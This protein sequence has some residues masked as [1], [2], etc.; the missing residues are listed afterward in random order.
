MQLADFGSTLSKDS[1]YAKQ[2]TQVGTPV[3]VGPEVF[4]ELQ[5]STSLDIWSFGATVSSRSMKQ[6]KYMT[7]RLVFKLISLMYGDGFDVFDPHIPE[8]HN[9]Y[10]AQILFK[11][12]RVFGPFPYE[13]I[14]DD[15][16]IGAITMIMQNSP[17]ETLRSFHRVVAK[18]I[19]EDDKAF[20][21]RIMKLDPRDR[22][23]AKQLLEDVWFR[24]GDA[25]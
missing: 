22:L 4:L 1:T 9:E 17:L 6:R 23:T 25:S 15:L 14:A 16:K 20:V 18:E 11:H 21:L 5:W 24:R 19:S 13:E 3:Y 7:D 2:G 10:Y 12:H 8:D